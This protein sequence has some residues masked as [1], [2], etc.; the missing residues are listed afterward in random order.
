MPL[1]RAD[2]TNGVGGAPTQHGRIGLALAGGGFLAAAWELGALCALSEAIEGFEPTRLDAYVGVSAGSFV[3]AGLVN[4]VTPH[5]MVQ[6]FVEGDR[7]GETLEPSQLLRPAVDEWWK[8]FRTL[9]RS[10]RRAMR[11]ACEAGIRHPQTALWQGIDELLRVLPDGFV[12]GQP[13]ERALA[14]LFGES[15]RT[16]DFRR[17]RAPLRIV[18][19]DIDSGMPVAFGSNGYEHVPISRAAVASSAVPGL[20]PPVR[21]GTHRY[22]DGALNKTLHAS[23]ALDAGAGLVFCLNPLV[24]FDGSRAGARRVSRSGPAAVLAQTMRATIRSRMTVGLEKY[25]VTHPDADIVLFEPHRDDAEIFFANIFSVASRRRLCEHAYRVTRAD[26]LER[27]DELAP[28]LQ[29]HGL[30]LDEAVLRAETPRLV[31]ASSPARVRALETPASLALRRLSATLH[32]LERS[33]AI[34]R[35]SAGSSR[36]A[37]DAA[38]SA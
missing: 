1:E 7:A 16:N 9:P 27:R 15:G 2:S 3:A 11:G 8:A 26:L 18:A 31:R 32:E 29:R 28:Q 21:I 12:D 30:S 38:R 34:A 25:R 17:T 37:P 6:L 36:R 10:L 19:T 14:H 33:L 35:A 22:V 5:R 13:G 20:F 4:G 23:L 24:P